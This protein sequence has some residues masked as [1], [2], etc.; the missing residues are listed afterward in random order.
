MG[1][2][3]TFV[4]TASHLLGVAAAVVGVAA[5]YVRDSVRRAIRTR[6]LRK[7]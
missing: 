4:V 2:S 1:H 3:T 7:E 5:L 6:I